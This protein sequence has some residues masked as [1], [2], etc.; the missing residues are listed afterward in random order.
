M[1]ASKESNPEQLQLKN[2]SR[3]PEKPFEN[4]DAVAWEPAENDLWIPLRIRGS[5]RGG[6]LG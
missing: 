6:V 2:V 1:S 4:G 5:W 3:E